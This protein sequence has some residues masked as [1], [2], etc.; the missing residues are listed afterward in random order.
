MR[1]L[2]LLEMHFFKYKGKVYTEVTADYNF[3]SRYLEVFDNLTVCA[4]MSEAGKNFDPSKYLLSSRE[5]VDFIELPDFQGVNGLIKN[6]FKVKKIIK[7]AIRTC[8]CAIFRVPSPISMVA[9][10]EIKKSGRPFAIELMMNPYTAHS[11]DAL[12]HP[13]QPIIQYLITKQTKNICMNANGVSY[14]TE[15]VLQK[16]YPCRAMLFNQD[17]DN[18]FTAE[19]STITLREDDFHFRDWK[20][21]NS[22]PIVLVHSGKME[23]YRKGQ[24]TFLKVVKK[25]V[26]NEK[27]V[28][29]IMIGDGGKRVEFEN[30]AKQF[31]ISEYVEFKGW[32]SGFDA[33][34]NELRKG[35]IFIFPTI[36]EGLPRS[37]IE[38]MANGLVCVSSPVDGVVE[39][40]DSDYLADFD[41]VERFVQIISKLMENP[42]LLKKISLFN[43][44]KAKKYHESMLKL[45]RKEFYLKLQA[46]SSY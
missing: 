36:G 45:K 46:I 2:V 10:S 40:I 35:D 22:N 8:N 15:Y 14:V 9:Y 18:Y 28:K 31:N 13:L 20:M 19:Y 23:N 12:K 44:E 38:A 42:E 43:T 3:W 39:L 26:E 6:Y 4:R 32:I 27:S 30:L 41:D 37:V 24:V 17:N 5:N 16:M 33:I 1:L 11:K 21:E 7:Q 25:L 34:K 29:A